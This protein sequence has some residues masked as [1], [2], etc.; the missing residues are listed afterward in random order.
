MVEQI[1]IPEGYKVVGFPDGPSALEAARKAS[2]SLILADFHLENMTFS[3]FCKEIGRL[4]NLAETLV[5]SLVDP[6]DKLDESKLRALGVRAFL[7]KPFQREQLL[8]TI[9]GILNDA[10]GKKSAAKPAKTRTW[11]PIFTE[12]NDEDDESTPNRVRR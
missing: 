1:S 5:I 3:G 11:P 10:A 8:D 9:N 4:D 2:P 7:K 12:T 6:S